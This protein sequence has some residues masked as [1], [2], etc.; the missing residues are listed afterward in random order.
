MKEAANCALAAADTLRKD[1]AVQN[2]AL[3]LVSGE[4]Y[5]WTKIEKY[6][7]NVLAIDPDNV[8]ANWMLAQF[9][10]IQPVEGTTKLTDEK[11]L[12]RER[13][14]AALAHL[15]RVKACPCIRYGERSTLKRTSIVGWPS[16]RV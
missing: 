1:L 5:D 16:D 3:R 14:E 13:V 2:E 7:D 10:F 9:N 15:E 6:A 11:N 4:P 8:R 12:N